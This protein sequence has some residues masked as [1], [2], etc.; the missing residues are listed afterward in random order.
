MYAHTHEP[1]GKSMYYTLAGNVYTYEMFF[2]CQRKL[3]HRK[4][5]TLLRTGDLVLLVAPCQPLL[6]LDDVPTGA[7]GTMSNISLSFK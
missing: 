5:T 1:W 3:L 4:V 2:S 7:L 6:E